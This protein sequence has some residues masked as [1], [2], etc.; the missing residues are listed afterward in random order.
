MINEMDKVKNIT[1]KILKDAALYAEEVVSNAKQNLSGELD[2][3]KREIERDREKALA[4]AKAS[5][6]ML[7]MQRISAAELETRK[8]LLTEKQE[9]LDGVFN[10]AKNEVLSMSDEAYRE[11]IKNLIVKNCI[12]SDEVIVSKKDERRLSEGFIK[13]AADSANMKLSRS[14]SG[15]FSGGVVLS[16]KTFDTVLTVDRIFTA[17]RHDLEIE[18]AEILF[19]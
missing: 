19:K 17:L 12:E 9:I 2:A 3:V 5:S 16:N 6:D 14:V 8:K 1:D 11:W 10:D 7:S 13:S 18:A 15:D 4:E